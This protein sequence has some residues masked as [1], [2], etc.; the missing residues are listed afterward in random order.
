MKCFFL[1]RC[2]NSSIKFIVQFFCC[3]L[4]GLVICHP[5]TVL[6]EKVDLTLS[7]IITLAQ[8]NNQQIAIARQQCLQSQG[9]LIQSKSGY[10]PHLSA[11]SLAS[12]QR[13]D[14][15]KPNDEDTVYNASIRASQL[16]YDF[17][18]TGGAIESSSMNLQA[19]DD[20]LFQVRQNVVFD[21]KKAFYDVLAKRRI[22]EVDKEA[23]SNYETQLYRAKKYYKAGVRTKID[24]TNAG[25]ELSNSRLSLIRSKSDLKTA[26]VKLEQILG[27][28]ITSGNYRLVHIDVPL[29]KLAVT[30]PDMP[31]SLDD[32]LAV[33][34]SQRSDVKGVKALLQAARAE[35]RKARSGYFPSVSAVAGYDEYDTDLESISN[36]WMLGVELTWELFSGF[37]TRGEIVSAR[38]KFQ[39]IKSALK[40]LEFAVRQEVTDSYLRAEEN[41]EGVNV[42]HETLILAKENFHMASERYKAGLNDM[43]EYNDAQLLLSRAQSNLIGTYYDYL[44]ALS[45]LE[46]AVGVTPEIKPCDADECKPCSV[47]L[48]TSSFHEDPEKRE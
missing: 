20:N 9:V 47:T 37:Q 39:E 15:L 11:G 27:Y 28:A 5:G 18:N 42:A 16:I 44:T 32:E 7:E 14:N 26:K 34:F 40:D 36:Q 25:V 1:K 21:S 13:I 3:F 6:A 4:A 17:G 2:R 43:I 29:E 22:V 23:V 35:I 48:Q 46:H 8:N 38:G 33:G 45:R 30:R 41:L 10:L 31:G 12:R 24:V 19:Q